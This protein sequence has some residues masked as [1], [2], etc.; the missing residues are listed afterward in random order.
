MDVH[1]E[2]GYCTHYQIK[3][4]F[5]RVTNISNISCIDM[6]KIPEDLIPPCDLMSIMTLYRDVKVNNLNNIMDKI[7]ELVKN[8]QNV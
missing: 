6:D 3:K 4:L 8:Y 5:E 2:L 7:I 1:L